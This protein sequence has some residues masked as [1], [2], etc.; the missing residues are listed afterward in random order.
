M[1]IGDHDFPK[2]CKSLNKNMYITHVCSGLIGLKTRILTQINLMQYLSLA[3]LPP[4]LPLNSH[5]T[6]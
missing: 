4:C 2:K 6:S 3:A 1:E 5:A